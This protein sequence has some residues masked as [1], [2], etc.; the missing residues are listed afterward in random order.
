VRTVSVFAAM[1]RLLLIEL[2]DTSCVEFEYLRAVPLVL[3]TSRPPR[4]Q[5]NHILRLP[6]RTSEAPCNSLHRYLI[7]SLRHV[8]VVDSFGQA[9]K[10]PADN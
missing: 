7:T 8:Q 5:L 10:S 2:H 3:L 6:R 9:G 1:R 4:Q